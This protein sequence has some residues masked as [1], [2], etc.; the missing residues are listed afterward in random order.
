MTVYTSF[1]V[2]MFITSI[3]LMVAVVIGEKE[4]ERKKK[5]EESKWRDRE[6]RRNVRRYMDRNF[7]YPRPRFE[8]NS[9]NIGDMWMGDGY[10][11]VGNFGEISPYPSHASATLDETITELA[12]VCDEYEATDPE[13]E[14]KMEKPIEL[15]ED[16]M[17]FD[18]NTKEI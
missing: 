15:P 5:R 12:R 6:R 14:E 16:F 7:D 4:K 13:P 17:L 9:P 8:E 11:R 10:V 3:I 1:F 2:G 18:L